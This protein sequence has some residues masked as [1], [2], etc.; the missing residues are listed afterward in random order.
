MRLTGNALGIF[1]MLLFVAVLPFNDAITK[2]LMADYQSGQVLGL[3]FAMLVA[4]L[5]PPALVLP[6]G[7]L[8][9]PPRR[10]LL[11]VRG[12]LIAAASMF[13]VS[14]LAYLPL[15]TVSAIAMLFPLIVTA[16]SPFFLGEKVGIVR[17][18]AVLLGFMGAVLVVQPASGGLGEG[19]LL[20]LGAPLCFS[21][22]I[23]LTRKMSGQGTQMGQ[24]FW[25][26]IGALLV[27][28]LAAWYTWQPLDNIAWGLVILTGVLALAIYILQI[29]SLQAGEASVVTPFSYLSLG[30]AAL[31]GYLIWGDWPNPMAW[32]GIGLISLSGVI[33]ALRS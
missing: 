19:K 9:A 16:I 4:L 2:I 20:A 31:T 27:T 21:A 3:R 33:V 32:A 6:A 30:T 24:L 12:V 13:Y 29:A 7:E 14:A 11:L 8:R 5:L 22:Y 10:G 18:S 15:A 23:I 26:M 28:G 1:Y 25:T 17:Y